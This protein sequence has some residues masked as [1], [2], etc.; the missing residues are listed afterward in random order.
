MPLYYRSNREALMLCPCCQAIDRVEVCASVPTYTRRYLATAFTLTCAECG[1]VMFEIDDELVEILR[2]LH[3]H[4]IP[5]QSHCAKIHRG[6]KIKYSRSERH[7]WYYGPYIM[8]DELRPDIYNH[9]KDV[10]N[11]AQMAHGQAYL[12]ITLE[13]EFPV[14]Q[15]RKG[16]VIDTSHTITLRV[17]IAEKS[18]SLMRDAVSTLKGIIM[19]WMHRLDENNIRYEEDKD[20]LLRLH[21]PNFTDPDPYWDDHNPF[22]AQDTPDSD[23]E[24]TK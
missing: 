6:R 1:T 8:F 7:G 2:E 3:R 4:Y 21:L 13:D 19:A 17:N 16:E 20:Q 14:T 22:K 9:L 15:N 24:E 18:E 12:I 11:I 10:V 5:T 23:G